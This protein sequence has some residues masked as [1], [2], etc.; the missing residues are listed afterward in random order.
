M[1]RPLTFEER[2]AVSLALKGERYTH[3]RW[4]RE[5]REA[6]AGAEVAPASCPYNPPLKRVYVKILTGVARALPRRLFWLYPDG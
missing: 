4:P 3:R 5:A 1:P 2:V 6:F